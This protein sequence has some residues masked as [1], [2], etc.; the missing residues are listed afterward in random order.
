M[1]RYATGTSNDPEEEDEEEY[2]EGNCKQLATNHIGG[3]RSWEKE[4]TVRAHSER[5]GNLSGYAT[6]LANEPKEEEEEEYV[7]GNCK[8]PARNHVGVNQGW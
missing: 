5:A 2:L 4:I 1:Y 6:G 7:A 8:Q 3:S